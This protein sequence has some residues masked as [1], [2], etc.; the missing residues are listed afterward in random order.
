MVFGATFST[1]VPGGYEGSLISEPL[2]SVP[3]HD[4]RFEGSCRWPVSL[5]WIVICSAL[6]GA[7]AA[8]LVTRC[9]FEFE[10]ERSVLT[11]V[12]EA[13]VNFSFW[14]CPG[15]IIR[16]VV[17]GL[18]PSEVSGATEVL[19]EAT[20]RCAFTGVGSAENA[21]DSFWV[22]EHGGDMRSGTEGDF[23][24]IDESC[25]QNVTIHAF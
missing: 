13:A 9:R 20:L 6:A 16:W 15:W 8:L 5:P 3:F 10:R 17:G 2:T 18:P 14:W 19:D 7:V 21:H 1:P 4:V 25:L 24:G 12:I 11:R 22:P 23:S